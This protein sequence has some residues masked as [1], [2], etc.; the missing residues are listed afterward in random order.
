[1]N[2]NISRFENFT[3]TVLSPHRPLSPVGRV[4]KEGP[5]LGIGSYQFVDVREV[6]VEDFQYCKNDVETEIIAK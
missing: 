3:S 5:E 4:D 2:I 1:M 6:V